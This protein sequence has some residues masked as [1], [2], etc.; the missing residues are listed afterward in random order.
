MKVDN[1]LIHRSIMSVYTFGVREHTWD[2]AMSLMLAIGH[3][4]AHEATILAE[5]KGLWEQVGKHFTVTDNSIKS[6][7]GPTD[8]CINPLCCSKP[9]AIYQQLLKRQEAAV[10]LQAAWRNRKIRKNFIP[11]HKQFIE[12]YYAPSGP[13]GIKAKLD[14]ASFIAQ[15]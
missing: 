10:V 6:N 3:G 12:R 13:G 5:D 9:R 15:I 8:F 4:F 1:N 14:L 11:T 7:D 2:Q